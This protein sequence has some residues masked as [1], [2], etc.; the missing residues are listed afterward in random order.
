MLGFLSPPGL[1]SHPPLNPGITHLPLLG[2]GGAVQ[3]AVAV[4]VEVEERLQH[5]QHARHLREDERP[6][7][8]ALQPPQQRVQLL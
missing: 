2:L 4:P 1:W 7:A 6:A 5:V 8:G 3:A